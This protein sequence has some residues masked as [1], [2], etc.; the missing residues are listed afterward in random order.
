[1]LCHF[2]RDSDFKITI[3]LFWK[4]VWFQGCCFLHQ[5]SLE[6]VFEVSANTLLC[7]CQ[8]IFQHQLIL[9][10]GNSPLWHVHPVFPVHMQ[11]TTPL[12]QYSP[13]RKD[14]PANYLWNRLPNAKK[15]PLHFGLFAPQ[16]NVCVSGIVDVTLWH[17]EKRFHKNPR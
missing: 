15:R 17:T 13:K 4:C 1:M 6:W 3:N 10:S 2:F 16:K 8:L 12:K 5:M 9:V 14:E 11:T 7:L